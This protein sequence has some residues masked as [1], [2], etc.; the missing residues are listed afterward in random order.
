MIVAADMAADIDEAR[1]GLKRL[2]VSVSI[3]SLVE[4][5][6]TELLKRRDLAAIMRRYGATARRRKES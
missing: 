5:A 3:S 1:A 4:I 6:V 2:G